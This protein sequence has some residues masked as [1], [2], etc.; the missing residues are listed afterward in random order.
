MLHAETIRTLPR[1]LQASNHDCVVASCGTAVG[2]AYSVDREAV[3]RALFGLTIPCGAKFERVAPEIEKR[4]GIRAVALHQA[5]LR[6]VIEDFAI[7]GEVVLWLDAAALYTVRPSP[8]AVFLRTSS[9][10]LVPPDFEAP[11]PV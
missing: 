3:R 8:H 1:V 6:E 10:P 4:F 2:S 11:L 9:V 7:R 5:P